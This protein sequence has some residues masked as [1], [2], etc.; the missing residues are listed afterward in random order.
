MTRD[1]AQWLVDQQIGLIGIDY[2]SIQ[3]FNNPPT[4]HEILL[5]G[6]IVILEG[7]NLADVKPG[8]YE[9]ICLPIRIVGTEGAPARAIRR[10]LRSDS[11]RFIY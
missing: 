8:K 4:T 5:K 11:D 3:I 2:L 7:L 10:Q 9:L 1:A 6:D